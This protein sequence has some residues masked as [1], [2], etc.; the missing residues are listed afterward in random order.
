[1]TSL[2]TRRALAQALLLRRWPAGAFGAAAAAAAAGAPPWAWRAC[3][4]AG[5]AAQGQP[6]PAPGAPPR[7]PSGD[8]EALGAHAR[9]VPLLYTAGAQRPTPAQRAAL[10]AILSRA[11]FALQSPTGSG[12][13][14]AYLVPLM[15]RLLQRHPGRLLRGEKA[16]T[17]RGVEALVIAPT[18]E[19]AMQIV[20]AA[21]A[22]LPEPARPA[23]QQ[24]IG[25]ASPGRQRES[26]KNNKVL[27]AVGTPGRLAKL[28]E[29]KSLQLIKETTLVFD[30]ADELWAMDDT[31]QLMGQ[32]AALQATLDDLRRE[33][34]ENRERK[35]RIGREEAR[36]FQVLLEKQPGWQSGQL[37]Q[38][39]LSRKSELSLKKQVRDL[40]LVFKQ[41]LKKEH[42]EQ[43]RAQHE[44]PRPL[45]YQAVFIG[46]TLQQPAVDAVAMWCKGPAPQLLR[47]PGPGGGGA[48]GA[49]AAAEGGAA[50]PEEGPQPGGLGQVLPAQV[51]H[52]YFVIRDRNDPRSDQGDLGAEEAG[53]DGDGGGGDAEG[54]GEA[55]DGGRPRRGPAPTSDRVA[56]LERVLSEQRGAGRRVLVF[57]GSGG[58]AEAVVRRL[59][60]GMRQSGGGGDRG[61]RGGRGSRS[62]GGG[63]GGS[64]W[65]V[66]SLYGDMPG[67]A[68]RAALAEF[69]A[70]G[71]DRRCLVLSGVGA[72]GLD[73]PSAHAAVLLDA[74]AGWRPYAH[75][76]GR[77]GRMGAGGVVLSIVTNAEARELAAIAQRLGIPLQRA[78]F[79]GR[80]L[81]VTP[82]PAPARPPPH[83]GDLKRLRA[84]A[85]A[86]AAADGG[87][88]GGAPEKG[89]RARQ[90]LFGHADRGGE[91]SGARAAAEAA[92]PG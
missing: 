75:R 54:G 16:V 25:G 61:D 19:L 22:L 24:L 62:D 63:G 67:P 50:A 9:L 66:S 88:G 11:H 8:W 91:E 13:T 45:P 73:L 52:A 6:P 30:E 68:R 43:R 42:K 23:V 34:R 41:R 89:A 14:L 57:V 12:K 59:Q 87:G 65:T 27:L 21:R 51:T 38:S 32:L 39:G 31:R 60:G 58:E 7:I 72:R 20:R 29:V 79:R 76:A 81:L 5:A 64:G 83:K 2:L 78:G 33:M 69:A 77:V 4:S 47:A 55:G 40:M 3:S 49:G 10:P 15:T 44:V 48:A 1:M 71:P 18:Q 56:V 70:P 92:P 74:P 17:Y 35:A 80:R 85:A 36:L 82:A 26:L 90:K 37:A 46:A 86:A 53:R 84:R 28:L